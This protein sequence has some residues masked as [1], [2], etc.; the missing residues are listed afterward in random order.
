[1]ATV[2]APASEAAAASAD[3]QRQLTAL[4]VAAAA[5]LLLFW[6]DAADMASIWWNS[7]TYNHCLFIPFIIG[8]LVWQRRAELNRL[9]PQAWL[10]ALALVGV[11]AFGWLLGYAGGIS[12]ARH[13]GLVLMLQGAVITL[14]GKAAARGLAF[15]IF[16]AFFAIPFGDEFVPPMQTLTAE[17]TMG[18]LNLT[19]VPA[20]LEG[21]FITTPAGYFEVA[22]ACAGV[23]F[24]V[25]MVALGALIANV[26]FRSWRRRALFLFAC[27]AVPVLANGVR[28]WGTIY[29]AEGTSVEFASGMDHVIYGGFFFA[30]VMAAIIGVAWRFFDRRI[31]DRWFEPTQLQRPGAAPDAERRLW[32]AAGLV[33]SLALTPILWST[34]IAAAGRQ[35]ATAALP[36]P[37]VPGWT[38]VQEQNGRPW[39]PHFAGADHLAVGHYRDETGR[40]VTLAVALFARQEQGRELVGFGQGAV[41]PDSDWAWSADA[42]PP[43][44]G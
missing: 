36:L 2:A 31:G 9:V 30:I 23:K 14:L 44:G 24:L 28:A 10:P 42:P 34:A 27:I 6:R 43:P 4:G 17:L 40:E 22:E 37:Q 20:L 25:A 16:Y 19:G 29:V 15:P 21:V 11:G 7:S 39:Q 3:W 8:W 13:A 12:L 38:Q 32:L 26:C 41:G 18:L 1:M 5:L 35:A 33:A